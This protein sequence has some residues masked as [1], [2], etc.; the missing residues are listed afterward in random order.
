MYGFGFKNPA[1]KYAAPKIEEIEEA[2]PIPGGALIAR[3]VP[4]PS[5]MGIGG[6]GSILLKRALQAAKFFAA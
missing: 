4:L 5:G 1:D 3:A 6:S 2:P